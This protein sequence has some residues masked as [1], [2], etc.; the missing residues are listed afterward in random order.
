MDVECNTES[1]EGRRGNREILRVVRRKP[2][3]NSK[4]SVVLPSCAERWHGMR[5]MENGLVTG[6]EER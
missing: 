4:V 2:A 6:G 5:V 3:Q 1:T